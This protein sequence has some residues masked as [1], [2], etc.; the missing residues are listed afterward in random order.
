MSYSNCSKISLLCDLPSGATADSLDCWPLSCD[1][2][3]VINKSMPRLTD[4][5]DIDDDLLYHMMATQSLTYKQLRDVQDE[6]KPSDRSKKLLT[7]LKRRG[8]CHL[9]DFLACLKETQP[10]LL[11]LLTGDFG[12]LPSVHL[13]TCLLAFTATSQAIILSR[14]QY[15]P[16]Q[17]VIPYVILNSYLLLRQ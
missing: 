4:L 2:L 12:N 11:P 13:Q 1:Q 7:M 3:S 9:N 14:F 17:H 16:C 10:H 5:L 8:I 6:N 15:V